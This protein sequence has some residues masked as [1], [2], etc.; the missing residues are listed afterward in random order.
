MFKTILAFVRSV[1]VHSMN[2]FFVFK[3]IAERA[4][5]IMG[6][7]DKTV[8]HKEQKFSAEVKRKQNIKNQ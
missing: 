5:L 8:L 6:G 1:A 2:T 7:K 4:P 3:V